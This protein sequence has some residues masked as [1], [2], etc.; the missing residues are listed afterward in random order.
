MAKRQTNDEQIERSFTAVFAKP[1]GANF[2]LADLH[3]HT[4]EDKQFQC[5]KDLD[6]STNKGENQ[7]AQGYIQAAKNKNVTILA[8]TEHNDVKWVDPTR[9]AAQGTEITV[10]PGIEL[11]AD[12]GAGG[13]HI[14]AIFEPNTET[15]FLDDLITQ[16]GL[17][18][19]Q[20]FHSD[21]SPR[22]CNKTL[23]DLVD[24][25]TINGGLCIAAH[26]LRDKGILKSESMTGEP[27]VKA[28][29][30]SKLLAAEIPCPR[31]GLSGFP[32]QVFENSH[33]LYRRP[34]PIAAIYS[35]DA[36]SFEEI[37]SHATWIK[38]S[39]KTLEGLKQAFLD[40]ESRIRHP[41][42]LPPERYSKIIAIRWDE[43][44][45]GGTSVRLNDNL[46]CFVGGKGTGKSTAI[47][48]LRHAFDLK[49]RTPEVI[50]QYEG[51]LKE[52]FKAGSKVSV[53]IECHDPQPTRYIIER[54]SPYPPIVKRENGEGTQGLSPCDLLCPEFYGQKEIYEI[55]Q[56]KELHLTLLDRFLGDRA[57]S[58]I[59]QE[60]DLLR[61]LA[62]NQK[63]LLR[64]SKR[65][66]EAGDQVGR[67]PKFLDYQSRFKA[68][69]VQ[70]K[71]QEQQTFVKEE[72]ALQ[73]AERRVIKFEEVL[74]S[75]A[76]EVNLDTAF[77]TGDRVKGLPNPELVGRAKSILETLRK[78][79]EETYRVLLNASLEARRGLGRDRGVLSEWE[80]KFKIR[81]EDFDKVIQELQREYPDLDTRNYL[82]IERQIAVLQPMKEEIERYQK[83]VEELKKQR[84]VLL[85]RLI[86]SRRQQFSV[87][88]QVARDLSIRLSGI[89][90]INVSFEGE[91]E[92]LVDKLLEYR[93][94]ARRE[95]LRAMVSADDFTVLK[96]CQALRAGQDALQ[97]DLGIT[98]GTAESLYKGT[99]S[100]DI[101]ELETFRIPDSTMIE[102]NIGTP[103]RED[104][105]PIERLSVGQRSTA[106]LLLILLESKAPLIIDQPEDDL[107]NQFI[108]E[109]IVAKLRQEKE[110]RQ[111]LVATH[112]ANIPVL[113]DAELILVMK[114]ETQNGGLRGNVERSGSIDD[115]DLREAVE[116]VLEGGKQAFELRKLKYG[117]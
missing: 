113:G 77:L 32:K 63:D 20:R 102:L 53:L 114:A 48:T 64:L 90:R 49:P 71:L 116:L 27:R 15:T 86:E 22:L 3:I 51:L 8:I 93:T 101:Y 13:I 29:Q 80:E 9:K 43:G 11:S 70:V 21:G 106:I 69:G 84:A 57:E 7:I 36:R 67:L 31:Q 68:A 98:G 59:Q 107:D 88:D 104:Y 35:S 111:F 19:G 46:N 14:I 72:K 38:L 24:F 26:V 55:A 115:P 5:P 110:R 105:R 52:T 95:A 25:I 37:G 41:T 65:V 12:S 23:S 82:E 76:T 56:K 54:I 99:P 62:D 30:N 47:E 89:M 75:I 18:L 16:L 42:E 100:E 73:E 81:K 40:W 94:G 83:Q 117:F 85:Q 17:P 91:R 97:R 44:F 45:L 78:K 28:W 112:N 109:D 58:A 61:Q 108:Y 74:K 33:N 92:A 79:W 34:L 66:A 2:H 6:P 50:R 1:N 39:S 60:R 87:R 10:F 103:D 4:P 96:F